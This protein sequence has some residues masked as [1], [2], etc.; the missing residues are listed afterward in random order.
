MRNCCFQDVLFVSCGMRIKT[1][2]TGLGL[3]AKGT[4]RGNSFLSALLI[5]SSLLLAIQLSSLL[6]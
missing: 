3:A 4:I 6:P 1:L 5:H 2:H